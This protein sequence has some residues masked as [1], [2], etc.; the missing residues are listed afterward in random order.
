MHRS[1]CIASVGLVQ[2]RPNKRTKHRNTN[3][4]QNRPRSWS[5]RQYNTRL[6]R[7]NED[8]QLKELLKRCLLLGVHPTIID[9]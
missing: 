1:T 8:E 5:D 3:V 4:I 7:P 2:A 6:M 9:Y